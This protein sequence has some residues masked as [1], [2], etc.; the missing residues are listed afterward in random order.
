MECGDIHTL[1]RSG[2]RLV[3]GERSLRTPGIR[4]YLTTRPGRGGR[5]TKDRLANGIP[6][7]VLQPRWGGVFGWAITQ[8]FAKSPHPWLISSHPSGVEEHLELRAGLRPKGAVAH[9]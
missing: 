5:T 1:R 9:V 4:A 2:R 8:G 3:R 6:H 7:S